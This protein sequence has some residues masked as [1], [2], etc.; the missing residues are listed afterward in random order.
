MPAHEP[1]EQLFAG[2][3][4]EQYELLKI[5][6]PAAPDMSRRLGERVATCPAAPEPLSVL[7]IGCGTGI[8]SIA[9]LNGRDDMRLTALDSEPTMLNQARRNL[10][11]WVEQGRLKLIEQDA[12]SVLRSLPDAGFDGVASAYTLHNFFDSYRT[13]VL[14]EILR[15]LRPGGW[16]VNG[17]RYAVDDVREH[18]RLTQEEMRVYFCELS[19]LQRYDV[20]EQ[21][22]VHLYGDECPDR[23][24]RLAPSLETMRALGYV[25]VAVEYRD[26]VNALVT[27]G[28]PFLKNS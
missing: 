5:I 24:M 8:T 21:W 23:I 26:G 12:L 7:E 17:D 18:C 6:C 22:I 25:G 15:I 14:A 13:D 19:R 3:I 9:L 27:A 1:V 28:K 20:L 11:R 4:G 2:L 10:A 16:F